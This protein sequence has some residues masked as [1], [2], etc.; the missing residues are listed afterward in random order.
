MIV[1]DRDLRDRP[2]TST[3]AIELGSSSSPMFSRLP[4]PMP[5]KAAKPQ[6][7]TSPVSSSAQVCPKP[8]AIWVTV[9]ARPR[10][11]GAGGATGEVQ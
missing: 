1:D 11:Q 8:V 5:P 9:D 7:C 6:Q 4:L 2:P 3:G 10:P